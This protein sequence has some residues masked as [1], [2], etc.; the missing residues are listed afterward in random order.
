MRSLYV[1]VH[2]LVKLLQFGLRKLKKKMMHRPFA[3]KPIASLPARHV[4][5]GLACA[6]G[7]LFSQS[8]FADLSDT[9]HPFI[10]SSISHDDNL[11]RLPDGD[12]GALG[13]SDTYKS[14]D[15]GFTLDRT[16][17]QQVITGRFDWS[18]VTF[19]RYTTLNYTSKNGDIALNWHLLS[20]LQGNVGASYMESLA[21][22]SD[23][24]SDQ[25]NLRIQRKA[26][27]DTTW[28]FHPSWQAR[29]GFKREKYEYDLDIQRFN[30][31]TDDTSELGVDYLA[32]SGSRVGLQAR[33]I[34][35][36]Y[37]DS[38]VFNG[39]RVDNDYGQDELKANVYWI[40]SGQTRVQFLGGW[41]RRTHPVQTVR[42]DSGTNGRLIVFWT[43]T[44]KL[45]FTGSAWREFAAYE[46]GI[47][48]SSL[49]KGA[50]L[51]GTWTFSDKVSANASLRN[52]KRDFS[53]PGVVLLE[54]QKDQTRNTTLGLT[55]APV[56]KI[57]L[58]VNAF[59]ETRSGTQS[60][61]FSTGYKAKGVSFN[62]T[63]QF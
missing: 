31:R 6:L 47:V 56:Q 59:R 1:A 12:N 11:L 52:E 27:A 35:G 10:Q 60:S 53:T 24:H 38:Q 48:A 40:V 32:V 34:K 62:G 18:R 2:L 55:Y 61:F 17:G 33:H 7:L 22:F 21:S 13:R 54:G 42:D 46:G 9:I 14:V 4:R 49:N 25:R 16:Y 20:H 3:K 26:F 23:F 37:P 45:K 19:D 50:S 58:T 41:E 36:T 8:A 63:V 43:P 44:G 39:I 15:G 5:T 30:N 28:Q 57:Q 29:A 51:L